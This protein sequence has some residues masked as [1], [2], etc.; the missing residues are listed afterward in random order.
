MKGK[1][2]MNT[3]EILNMYG[4]SSTRLE[5]F[6]DAGLIKPLSDGFGN[7]YYS[8]EDL[9]LLEIIVWLSKCDL[10]IDEIK[11]VFNKQISL[12]QLLETKG[13]KVSSD[14]IEK[15]ERNLLRRK[16]AFEYLTVDDSVIDEN[17]VCFKKNELIIKD[18]YNF[19]KTIKL[20]Y[21][22]INE[23][24]FSICTRAYTD[25]IFD[26]RNSLGK[27]GSGKGLR[28]YCFVDLDVITASQELFFES[29]SI[30]NMHDIMMLIKEQ[31]ILVTDS[32]GL[33]SFFVENTDKY[34]FNK[35]LANN[36]RSWTKT[37]GIDNPRSVEVVS[38]MR[39]I[40]NSVN[41][42]DYK[43]TKS[44][45]NIHKPI[46][47]LNYILIVILVITLALCIWGY[48]ENYVH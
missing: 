8:Q 46:G 42:D 1:T 23:L 47:Q 44:D 28:T 18:V 38:Q 41:I 25:S 4:V 27:V 31:N 29:I 39:Q 48:I 9:R 36:I 26:N 15:I 24:K 43:A 35:V 5:Q 19:E 21:Q 7:C 30:E 6:I 40:R 32:L 37:C 13:K 45:L 2:T 22:E 14:K 12:F 11:L 16:A 10:S 20:P 3:Q 17:Y 33:V 34:K